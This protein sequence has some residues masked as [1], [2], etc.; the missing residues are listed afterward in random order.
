[1]NDLKRYRICMIGDKNKFY[2]D[3]RRLILKKTIMREEKFYIIIMNRDSN[4]NFW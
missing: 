3:R 4:F 2:V 1:M